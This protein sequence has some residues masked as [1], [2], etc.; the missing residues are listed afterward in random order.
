[1][2][3]VVIAVTIIMTPAAYHRQQD[4][5]EVT[6]LFVT[7]SSRLLLWSML[8]LAIALSLDFYLIMIAITAAAWVAVVSMIVFSFIVVLWFILPRVGT[9]KRK[10]TPYS[11]CMIVNRLRFSLAC[12]SRYRFSQ[13]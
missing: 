2:G 10:K 7:I 12:R 6:E 3:L 11:R 5:G 9:L 1:I 8:P 13:P 4:R